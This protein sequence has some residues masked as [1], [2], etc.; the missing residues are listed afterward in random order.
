MNASKICLSILLSVSPVL[1]FEASAGSA[2]I[3]SKD[4]ASSTFEYSD[5]YLRISIPDQDGYAVVR[6]GSI[7]TV[8][9]QDGRTLVIDAGSAMKGMGAG[10]AT[11]VPAQFNSEI[12]S[13]DKTGRTEVVA[14]IKG[15]VYELNFVDENGNEQIEE[16][17]LSDDPRALEFRDGLFLMM[18]VASK[19]TSEG[20]A[21]STASIQ[22]ALADINSG[23]LRYG[24]EMTV[25]DINGDNIDP[26][27]FE[28]PAEPLNLQGIG[29]MLRNMSQQAPADTNSSE[30]ADSSA[31]Q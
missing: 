5:E 18:G 11:T 6:D 8:M 7:Y 16:V 20:T 15:D 31:E 9:Q 14:G 3:T 21:D 10:V 2:T 12:G 26:A 29:A 19:L 22:K 28:L 24:Q 30:A 1:V 13:L 25:T 4:G 23:L 17:V 27:R